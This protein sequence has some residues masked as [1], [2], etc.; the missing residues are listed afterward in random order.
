MGTAC[1]RGLRS[2]AVVDPAVAAKYGEYGRIFREMVDFAKS[3]S[4]MV[5]MVASEQIEADVWLKTKT[6]GER[7]LAEYIFV[8]A[9]VFQRSG[10][11]PLPSN[12]RHLGGMKL[13]ASRYGKGPLAPPCNPPRR[14]DVVSYGPVIKEVIKEASKLGEVAD[15]VV[16]GEL[17]LSETV[18]TTN[19]ELMPSFRLQRFAQTVTDIHAA[20][21]L[22]VAQTGGEPEISQ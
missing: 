10:F 15:E 2:S 19:R 3:L 4:D 12:R 14:S 7:P 16:R 5:E 22:E 6:G 13:G 18:G 21:R 1:S 11:E 20:V 17:Q 8:C 9:T